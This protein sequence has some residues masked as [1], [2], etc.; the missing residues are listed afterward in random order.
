MQ[1]LDLS[2]L[3]FSYDNDDEDE[4]AKTVMQHFGWSLTSRQTRSLRTRRLLLN[5]ELRVYSL[6]EGLI[7]V[8]LS[9]SLSAILSDTA[10]AIILPIRFRTDMTIVSR[11]RHSSRIR[12][13]IFF[14]VLNLIIWTFKKK[15]R[16]ERTI[17]IIEIEKVLVPDLS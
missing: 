1:I 12:E 9:L 17:S 2:R 16:E 5:G 6:V 11:S 3:S 8:T 7:R 14:N 10:L 13:F 15:I 4:T